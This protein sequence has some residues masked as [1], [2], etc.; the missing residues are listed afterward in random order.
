MGRRLGI[1]GLTGGQRKQVE[2]FLHLFADVE[3][4]LK[5]RLGRRANDRTVVQAMIEA[6]V[7]KNP[8]WT[9]SANRLRHL[10]DIRNV[11]I[12]QCGTTFGYPI[13]VAPSS[14]QA[15]RSIKEQLLKP[16]P[17]SQRYRRNVKM[18]SAADSIASVLRS[19]FE[20]GYSQFPVLSDGQFGG[21][22]TENEIIRWLGRQSKANSVL[23]NLEVVTVRMVLKEKDPF[24][25]GIAI[26]HFEKL[27]APL[28]EVMGRFSSEP[29][30]EVI[31]LTETG[32]KQAPIEGIVTQWDA[33]RYPS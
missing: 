4:A 8:Y 22:I 21:L 14:I 15:L 18:V 20:N 6:V 31:L 30:L 33:A 12:H 7:A 10:A 13:A 32:N 16:E 27:D 26:F 11:L 24:L 28:D 23:I 3:A 9:D 17:A 1:S 29:A 25:R 5:K 2:V 19:A